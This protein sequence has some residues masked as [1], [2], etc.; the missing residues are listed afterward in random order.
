[1][2]PEDQCIYCFGGEDLDG[3]LL[4]QIEQ[5]FM[6]T[7]EWVIFEYLLP[8]PL[9]LAV[10]L[11]VNK[12]KILL[13]GGLRYVRKQHEVGSGTYVSK[14]RTD[15]VIE[16]NVNL[17]D[18]N[19]M[20]DLKLL[21]P[22]LSLYPCFYPKRHED[23]KGSRIPG[24]IKK[25][26]FRRNDDQTTTEQ[27]LQDEADNIEL[28]KLLK[29]KAQDPT[30]TES[31]VLVFLINEEAGRGTGHEDNDDINPSAIPFSIKSFMPN[32]MNY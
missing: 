26:R 28:E 23:D 31:D 29:R 1:V 13:F 24:S 20:S 10:P 7:N 5:Y 18:I 30:F 21:K 3:R 6:Q 25:G 15:E 12:R 22:C 16:F 2:F 14:E 4:N 8:S 19:V 32:E 9:A 11:K 27:A 17:K